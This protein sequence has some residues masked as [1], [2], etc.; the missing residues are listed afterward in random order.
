MQKIGESAFFMPLVGCMNDALKLLPSQ[1]QHAARLRN[2]LQRYG[3]AL[4]AS[5]PGAGKTYVA[6]DTAVRMGLKLAVIAPKATLPAWR[7]VAAAFGVEVALVTNYENVRTGKHPLCAKSSFKAFSGKMKVRFRWALA[8]DTLLVLDEVHRCRNYN[9]ANAQLLTAAARQGIKTLICSATP[10]ISPMDCFAIGAALRLF[11][12]GMFWAWAANHSCKRGRYGWKFYGGE[13]ELRCLHDAIFP[14]KGSRLTLADIPEFP[15][16]RVEA[17]AVDTGN[18]SKIQAIYTRMAQ[19][20]KFATRAA[21]TEKLGDLAEKLDAKVATQMT[22]ILR[23]RAAVE[24]CKVSVLAELAEDAMAQGESVAVFVNFKGTVEALCDRL[25]CNAVITGGQDEADRQR[26]VDAF[27]ANSI[28]LVICNIAA[29]GVGVS[30]HDPTGQKPRLALISPTF[31][32]ID[33]TQALGRVHRTHGATSRQ[34]VVFADGTCE[35]E[36]CERVAAKCANIALVTDGD[37][38][39]SFINETR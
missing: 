23:A 5:V 9:T 12:E 18:A 34:L 30:L 8:P 21:D 16:T 36:T 37:L 22:I 1:E 14:A 28:P 7:K 31:S 2:S 10:F 13:D 20:L 4:D 32:A 38:T 15:E 19:E 26:V 6:C 29:G 11:P 17:R 27:Q 25:K 35:A 33:L 39:P 24:M 3:C